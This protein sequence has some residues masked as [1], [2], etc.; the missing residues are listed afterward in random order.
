MRR[1]RSP[2]QIARDRK[3]DSKGRF[4]RTGSKVSPKT[5]AKA[6]QAL[7]GLRPKTRLPATVKLPT[8][9]LVKT[10]RKI[11]VRNVARVKALL[12][13]LPSKKQKTPDQLRRIRTRKLMKTIRD[14]KRR[15]KRLEREQKRA[16]RLRI[17]EANKAKREAMKRY[18]AE[19]KAVRGRSLPAVR[20]VP[21]DDSIS[22]RNG[23]LSL[24]G[25]DPAIAKVSAT[26]RYK[27][28][29]D[30][31]V[32][33][34][35]KR[36]QLNNNIG[37]LKVAG[38]TFKGLP[39][40]RSLHKSSDSGTLVNKLVRHNNQTVGWFKYGEQPSAETW[41]AKSFGHI[42]KEYLRKGSTVGKYGTVQLHHVKQHYR[43]E[44]NQAMEGY[45]S[46]KLTKEQ[47][48]AAIKP[49]LTEVR[50]GR[51]E[52]KLAD[53]SEREY[54]L[55]PKYTHEAGTKLFDAN[56]P[57][58]LDP[59]TG[60]LIRPGIPKD[61]EGSRKDYAERIRPQFWA[62]YH[63]SESYKI[64][65]E[66]NRR[67]KNGELDQKQLETMLKVS[68][69]KYRANEAGLMKAKQDQQSR[70]DAKLKELVGQDKKSTESEILDFFR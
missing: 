42:D 22:V 52:I 47:A 28:P 26:V 36:I 44:V 12:S 29:A 55:L 58:V 13:G 67:L 21:A 53:R 20:T 39:D 30:Y 63:R 40:T 32:E 25:G 69:S 24:F 43:P 27:K 3:R 56:H 70:V 64:S 37:V 1:S 6:K 10:G 66:L 35:G 49:H 54:I 60:K 5:V 15:L 45:H 57:K 50:P 23:R 68:Q 46:G 38:E 7:S 48:Q 65:A 33:Y 17:R 19:L 31:G 2:N 51:Y 16:E 9:G 41:G 8:R 59:G 34:D 11:A 14:E 4:I 61:G 18:K 62:E